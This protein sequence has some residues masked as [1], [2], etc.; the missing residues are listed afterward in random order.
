VRF[1]QFDIDHIIPWHLS[2]DAEQWRR[3]LAEL[4]LDEPFDVDG[5]LNLL[6]TCRRHNQSKGDSR[7]PDGQLILLLLKA[8]EKAPRVA[9][10][11]AEVFSERQRSRLLSKFAKAAHE[12]NFRSGLLESIG[13][14][15]VPDPRPSIS[16]W[17]EGSNAERVTRIFG[18]ASANLLGWPQVTDGEWFDRPE[19]DQ[20][21]S[22]VHSRDG[23]VVA[24]LGP[25]GVGKS[26]LLARLGSNLI[27][28]GMVLLGI[29][30]D[31]LPRSISSMRGL[32][33]EWT[34]DEP[35]SIVL[36]RLA[37]KTEVA[38][39]IDQL[40]ALGPLMDSHP[41]R[42]AAMISLINSARN[43]PG[44]TL[45]VSCRSFDADYDLRLKALFQPAKKVEMIDPPWPVVRP[46]LARHGHNPDAWPETVRTM[47]SRPYNLKLFLSKIKPSAGIPAFTSLHAM[48]E[49]VL[50]QLQQSCGP[51]AENALEVI[52]ERMAVEENLWVPYAPLRRQFPNEIPQL[53]SNELV[54]R[55]ASGMQLGLAHQTLF[56]FLRG[57][58]FALGQSSLHD[59]IRKKQ[60]G[61]S[62]RPVLWSALAYAR[63]SDPGTYQR[64]LK[65]VF[66]DVVVRL[67]VKLLLVDFLGTVLDPQPH[68]AER[69]RLL[70]PDS[71]IRPHVMKAIENKT[72]WFSMLRD[73]IAR[74]S[75][76]GYVAA[77]HASWVLGPALRFDE[78]FVLSALETSW[79]LHAELDSATFNVFRECREWT[80]RMARIMERVVA[81]TAIWPSSICNYAAVMNSTRSDLAIRLI[82]VKLDFDLTQAKTSIGPIVA[83]DDDESIEAQMNRYS[84]ESERLK[85]LTHLLAA[86]GDWY[87]LEDIAT[88]SPAE[89]TEGLWTWVEDLSRSISKSKER[90]YA[91]EDYEWHFGEKHSGSPL[92]TS[93]WKAV[94]LFAKADPAR[95]LSWVK[96][97]SASE[98]WAVHRLIRYG[99]GQIAAHHAKAVFE[100]LTEAFGRLAI[101]D[102]WSGPG[103]TA[104]LLE[105]IKDGVSA[106]ESEALAASINS[107]LPPQTAGADE[108]QR[109]AELKDWAK[110]RQWGLD[111]LPGEVS[112]PKGALPFE[113]ED[114]AALYPRSAL[115]V[116][117][118]EGFAS[119]DELLLALA[120]W[121]DDRNEG[122][123]YRIGGSDHVAGQFG[124]FVKKHPER[125]LALIEQLQPGK[126][127]KAAA[128][129]L[130]A[131]E[132]VANPD[133][134][135]LCDLIHRLLGG[136]HS[137][138][139]RNRSAWVLARLAQRGAGLGEQAI[140]DLLGLLS[141]VEAAVESDR[142]SSVIE[143]RP[144]K[145]ES[146][147]W[148]MRGHFIPDGNYPVLLGLTMGLLRNQHPAW[149][150]LVDIF[151]DHLQKGES[152]AVWQAMLDHLRFLRGN[153]RPKAAEFIA[154]VFVQY[155]SLFASSEGVRCVANIHSWLPEA[156]FHRAISELAQS[157][158][159]LASRAIGEL[160]MLRAGL[161]PEDAIAQAKL[162]EAVT[163][164]AAGQSSDL[165][166]GWVTSASQTWMSPSLRAAST[167]I[168][169]A[170]APKAAGE[171]AEAVANSFVR[172]D[173]E[174]LPGDACTDELLGTL[175]LNPSLMGLHPESLIDR[176][177]ELLQEGYSATMVGTICRLLIETANPS[178]REFDSKLYS[179]GL[180]DIAITL[181]RFPEARADGTWIF[182]ELLAANAYKVEQTKVSLD[183]RML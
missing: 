111:S 164:L 24:L 154:N 52:A 128:A 148:A 77:W 168:L 13:M 63:A 112:G 25:P 107:W 172:Q 176:L 27:S 42:L 54:R 67:H 55:D 26:A 152:P 162:T 104:D 40:D 36:G 139:F 106:E 136:F 125:G 101:G 12:P 35:L 140:Q 59:E 16:Q 141:P 31:L 79:M 9:R 1:D 72:A 143:V 66:E 57:R 75:D 39:L 78:G 38:I 161:I 122:D 174:D 126:Q 10:L 15:S 50:E 53:L 45:V 62:I 32:E 37:T 133:V 64:E 109:A 60:D 123:D 167:Q 105:A 46:V 21:I 180:I 175:C 146:V 115:S 132:S 96:L 100:Y 127:E 95:F 71:R 129:A 80:D 7:L 82:R 130:D 47:L 22:A 56:E 124:E 68:E 177:K 182:E 163:D 81:R 44:V 144:P 169:A 116:E 135:M 142:T 91:S 20:L 49:V 150:R 173:K 147:L 155:P 14:E 51:Q 17:P 70:I 151:A 179:S 153:D 3:V 113:D 76:L 93:L 121:P 41:E 94:A 149:E 158:W 30:A 74:C 131:L 103:R 48:L 87:A 18:E 23:N 138:H 120:A 114:D 88:T 65:R 118:M 97:A 99:L 73:S 183:G 165:L 137:D 2:N 33:P 145:A 157:A 11:R 85:P 166:I 43:I 29:K 178:L 89:L 92:A 98:T 58:A 34:L 19:L 170:A 8:R 6:P 156:F 108:Q 160:W 5:D 134:A 84:L 159:P 90:S 4:S 61:L 69:L 119:D 86:P 83:V 181:Q 102:S 28:R 110:R 117:Q 171:I